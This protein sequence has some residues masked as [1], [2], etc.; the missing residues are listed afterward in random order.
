MSR[1]CDFRDF[2]K[3]AGVVLDTAEEDEGDGVAMFANDGEDV[4]GL[5]GEAMFRFHLNDAVD[6]VKSMKLHLTLER[7]VVRRKRLGLHQDLEPRLG[8]SVERDHQE[9]DVDC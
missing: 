1:L 3:L 9:M 8:G 2:E 7:K 4:F 6:G 5:K